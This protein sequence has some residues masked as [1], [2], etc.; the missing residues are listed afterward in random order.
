MIIKQQIVSE[1]QYN[2]FEGNVSIMHKSIPRTNVPSNFVKSMC[3]T[4]F[5]CTTFYQ[6][7]SK[8]RTPSMKYV[9][10]HFKKNIYVRTKFSCESSSHDLC[11]RTHVHSSERTLPRTI[12]Y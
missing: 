11:A 8:F 7:S 5:L 3:S 6:Q 2:N 1:I 4:N 12:H 10:T 9:Q